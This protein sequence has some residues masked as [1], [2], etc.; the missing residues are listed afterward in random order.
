MPTVTQTPQQLAA[1][2]APLATQIPG[3]QI[4]AGFLQNPSPPCIDMY[5]GEPFQEGA[6]FGTRDKRTYWTVRARVQTTD[7]DAANQT[8]LRF[9]DPS[10]TASVEAA[11]AVNQLATVD[12][13][14]GTV[15]GFRKYADDNGTDMV[16][17]EWRVGVWTP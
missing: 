8:L 12:S 6:G 11:L 13:N 2:L 17:C 4:Y 3:L 7:M 5:P 9:L 10:D 16:G 14:Q 1:A 15:S